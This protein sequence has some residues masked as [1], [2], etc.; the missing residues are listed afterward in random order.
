MVLALLT[1]SMTSSLSRGALRSKEAADTATT[2]PKSKQCVTHICVVEPL[3]HQ[4]KFTFKPYNNH[5][6]EISVILRVFVSKFKKLLF[7]PS[8][9]FYENLLLLLLAEYLLAEG[10]I[11]LVINTTTICNIYFYLSS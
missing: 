7:K 10:P 9:P 5:G 4:H 3:K 8:R 6:N 2:A 1:D 11:I